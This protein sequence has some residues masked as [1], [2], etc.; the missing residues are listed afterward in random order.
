MFSCVRL[1]PDCSSICLGFHSRRRDDAPPRIS[2]LPPLPRET[3]RSPQIAC[4]LND[5]R[6][7]F[8]RSRC[9]NSRNQLGAFLSKILAPWTSADPPSL[10]TRLLRPNVNWPTTPMQTASATPPTGTA[11]AH[12]P[13]SYSKDSNNSQASTL[14]ST[15]ARRSSSALVSPTP[16]SSRKSSHLQQVIYIPGG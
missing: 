14:S 1:D 3:P 16:S 6:G 10:P 7:E 8:P 9:G 12:G 4:S 11:S 2:S 13:A 5:P 15:T